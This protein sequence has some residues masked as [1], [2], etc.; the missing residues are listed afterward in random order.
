MKYCQKCGALL[1]DDAIFCA[2]CGTSFSAPG[3][4]RS[5]Y[6]P[7]QAP[8]QPM[9]QRQPMPQQMPQQ[10]AATPQAWYQCRNCNA[11]IPYSPQAPIY[12]CPVCGKP[13]AGNTEQSMWS[14]G[15]ILMLVSII[16]T[17]V[18][19]FLPYLSYSVL[20]ASYNIHLWSEKFMSSAVITVGFIFIAFIITGLSKKSKGTGPA[21]CAV[22]ILIDLYFNYTGNQKRLTNF[23]SGFGTLDL[24]GL[25]SPGTGFY[26]MV[27]GCVGM[28]IS[29]IVMHI[30]ASKQ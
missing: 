1:P 23:D 22:V 3:P 24:S 14:V 10:Y 13:L 17:F 26:L 4:Q 20:G 28:I 2:N 27:L 7:Q 18:G 30:T 19:T 11:M 21:L 5:T 9:Q 25:L 8:E 29:C 12:Q 6:Q 16:V 15:R